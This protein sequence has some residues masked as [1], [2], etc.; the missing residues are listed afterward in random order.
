MP[1][2]KGSA[3]STYSRWNL[4][5]SELTSSWPSKFSKVKLTLTRL[6]SSSAH[7]EPGYEGTPT[8]YCKD[9]A[10]FDASAV[11]FLFVL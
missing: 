2:R 7:P 1:E 11:S 10:A 5:T 3:N 4:N 9:Q 6:T 8:D